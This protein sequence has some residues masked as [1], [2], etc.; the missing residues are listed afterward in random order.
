M[1]QLRI[2]YNG[3]PK[4]DLD[5]LLKKYSAR[6]INMT[7]ILDDIELYAETYQD[8]LDIM[9]WKFEDEAIRKSTCSIKFES[10][11]KEV[12]EIQLRHL[13][14]NMIFWYAFV[15]ADS[16]E[17]VNK[18][19]IMD[20][21][22]PT[23]D[24]GRISNYID[25]M[26][27]PNIAD[28]DLQTKNEIV[29]EIIHNM[30]AI[31]RAFSPLMG[32]GI[33]VYSIIQA[34]KRNPRI[35]Q[36]MHEKLPDGLQ[37][38][39]IEERLSVATD[40]LIDLFKKDQD[41]D[42][43]PLFASGN[44]LSKGQFKE[45]A[46]AIGLK[47]D[48]NGNTIPHLIKCNI[49]VDGISTPSA[50]YLDGE[51]GRKALILSKTRM[52]EPG[53][54]SKKATTNTTSVVLRHDYVKCH[55]VRPAWYH[56]DSDQFLKLLN[57][58]YYYEDHLD[59]EG[60]PIEHIVNYKKDKWMI[61]K[62]IPFRSPC[63]CASHHG[64]CYACY[65]MLYNVNKDLASAGAY[66]A[67]KETEPLGQAVLSSK[68]LQMTHSSTIQFDE[69][70]NK[71]FDLSSNE[72]TAKDEPEYDEELYLVLGEV[73]AEE[74]EDTIDYYCDEFDVVSTQNKV[75][76]HVAEQNHSRLYL[77]KQ[78]ADVYVKL[79]DKSKPISM[80]IFDDDSSV[81]FN[82]EI[83][84]KELTQPIRNINRLLNTVDK[85]GCT[86]LDEV[87][88]QF[89]RNKIDAGIKYD[90]VHDEMMIRGLLRKKSNEMEEPDWT[91]NGD[92]NDYKILRLNDALFKNPSPVVSL[93]YG[94]LR[95]Q[96]RSPE[97]Y[98]KTAPSHLD[99]LFVSKLS[100]TITDDID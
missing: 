42:L 58:R 56:I 37:P 94:Y 44:N 13:L 65:G 92:P 93:S 43:K 82:V 41:N 26:I 27:L 18:S 8:I 64:I 81:I 72:I 12:I 83:K 70:F 61:G 78:L 99:P 63:T 52:G 86:T 80:N 57:G 30:T 96:L 53:A 59:E 55:S 22:D 20:F 2:D 4:H 11:P 45:I 5:T 97:F 17:V 90:L 89:A 19:F 40:E 33:S 87:C 74:T 29:D 71:V 35:E 3:H 34:A 60:N 15:R 6:I 32:L 73:K 51:S 25:D 31:S 10:E 91:A 75:I 54:F 9:K 66:A 67:T 69:N 100:E 49:L 38:T 79:K 28:V 47:A 95:K 23:I 7:E 24:M 77:S 46:V 21:T 48:V 88:Q 14:T 62:D 85:C 84:N 76:F 1:A 36:I 98:N 68:H 50:Y 39:E 16:A